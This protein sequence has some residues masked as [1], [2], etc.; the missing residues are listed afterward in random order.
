MQSELQRWYCKPGDPGEPWGT[1]NAVSQNAVPKPASMSTSNRT[2]CDDT[3][4][5]QLHLTTHTEGC[6]GRILLAA[7]TGWWHGQDTLT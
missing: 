7:L 2:D 4:A 6:V 1:T 3:L 5:L